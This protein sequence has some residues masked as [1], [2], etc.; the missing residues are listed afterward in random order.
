MLTGFDSKNVEWI[1]Q[2]LEQ[3]E[4]RRLM[5]ECH[6]SLGQLSDH[7]RLTRTIPH[8]AFESIVMKIPYL[9]ARNEAVLELLTE[10]QTCFCSNPADAQDLAYKILWVKNNYQVAQAI[11]E[12][13]YQLYQKKLA[14]KLLAKNVLN[15]II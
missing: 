14:P 1:S 4:L 2:K 7:E 10:N 6:L 11:A 8:K 12:N 13:A 3:N 15:Q 5:Q 9:T